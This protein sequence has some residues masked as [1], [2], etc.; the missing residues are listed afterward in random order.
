[1]KKTKKMIKDLLKITKIPVM[2]VLPGQIAFFV[3]L[4]IFPLLTL[5]G[6]IASF[7]SIS[8]SSLIVVIKDAFP[9]EITEMLI[10]FIQGKGFILKTGLATLSLS[11]GLY[12]SQMILISDHIGL[13]LPKYL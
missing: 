11:L 13:V 5:V 12:I 10:T 6:V 1:M 4:A 7:F 3:V 8:V 2:K 9:T